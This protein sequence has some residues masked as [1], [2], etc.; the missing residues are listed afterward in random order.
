MRT[1]LQEELLKIYKEVKRVCEKNKISYFALGGT[2]LGAVRHEGFIPWDDDIDLGV[3]V[4]QYEKFVKALKKDLNEPYE[5]KDLLWMGGKVHNKNTA[6]IETTCLM[7][8][9]NCYG[10]FL[11]VFPIIG[12]PNEPAEREKFIER[13]RFFKN[14]SLT[15]DRYRKASK[16]SLKELRK[17]KQEILSQNS[18]SE[19]ERI[20]EFSFGYDFT[21]DRRGL[22]TP[23]IV[24]F[25]DTTI[26]LSSKIEEDL[27]AQY[28]DYMKLPPKNQRIPH[29]DFAIVDFKTPYRELFKELYQNID[30]RLLKLLEQKHYLEGVYSDGASYEATR[31]SI[32]EKEL[33][34][35]EKI[36]NEQGQELGTLREQY[37]EITNSRAYKIARKVSSLTNKLRRR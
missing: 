28:G 11:D 3:P 17:E 14:N 6:F 32:L 22:E 35:K 7:D 36:I 37:R 20:V 15:F 1:R 10:I 34:N 19:A 25:E 18:L 33:K 31:N 30:G 29:N 13:M 23:R 27:T 4:D 26:P 9:E 2:A 21:R 12:T 16:H 24:K 8:V 5:Y